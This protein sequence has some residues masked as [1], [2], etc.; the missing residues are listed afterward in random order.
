MRTKTFNHQPNKLI[1]TFILTIL[2]SLSL[3]GCGGGSSGD[4]N[5]TG[6]IQLYNLSDNAPGVYLTLDI[7]DDDDFDEKTHS[8]VQFG[9]ISGHLAY[10]TDTYDIELAWQNEYNNVF[11]L[12]VVHESQL[13]VDSD[14]VELIV[15][16][17]DIRSLDVLSY[18]IPVR[19]NDEVDDDVD[20]D[21]FNIRVLNMHSLSGGVDMY[22]SESD[23]TFNEAKLLNE[24]NYS[25]ISANQK[26]AQDGYTFYLTAAGSDEVLYTSENIDFPYASEYIIVIKE[27]TGV[28]TSNFLLDIITTS[29]VTEF[30]DS[31]SEASYRIF[32]AIVKHDKIPKYDNAFNFHLNDIDDSPEV[33][34][35]NFGKFSE[36]FIIDSGDYSMN[37]VIPEDKNILINNHLLSLNEN[38]DK[39]VFFYLLEE[40]VDEDEDGDIDEDGDGKIDDTKV[41]VN[42]LTVDNKLSDN[43]Y[44]HQMNVINL[45]D[46]DEFINDFSSIKVYFVRN[47]EEINT[48]D[49]F[50]TT[51][52][53]QP[54]TIELLNNTYTVYVIGSLDSSNI[55]LASS[56]LILNEDSKNQFIILEKVVNTNDEYTMRFENQVNN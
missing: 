15:L 50:L 14:T 47:D 7:N 33:S 38:T 48:A 44:S 42:S 11:D 39:T 43:I 46:Q 13:K 18:E 10:E 36:S 45:I 6:Y 37:L 28:G 1:S 5:N 29:T 25:E 55:I 35:L 53:A 49:Q 40:A 4:D 30:P 22:Y 9:K 24:T 51:V 17:G 34:A 56:E 21:V 23:E 2:L 20:D 12:E 26:I 16:T 52:F 54:S 32:N 27:N 19:D 3:L 8:P 41:I 31:D